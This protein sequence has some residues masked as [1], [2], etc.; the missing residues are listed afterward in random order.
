MKFQV[1]HG[2]DAIAGL[3]RNALQRYESFFR[4]FKAAYVD[5]AVAGLNRSA[6]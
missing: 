3:S 2:D 1:A 4:F 5:D 6:L